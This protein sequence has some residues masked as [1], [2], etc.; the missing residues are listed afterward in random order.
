MCLILELCHFIFLA[1]FLCM[2]LDVSAQGFTY[3]AEENVQGMELPFVPLWK[4]SEGKRDDQWKIAVYASISDASI[5]ASTNVPLRLL[6]AVA[7][8]P[9]PTT[10][11][12]HLH[13]PPGSPS[14]I[15]SALRCLCHLHPHFSLCILCH[16][17]IRF[18]QRHFF[19]LT[20][21]P[22]HPTPNF[23]SSRSSTHLHILLFSSSEYEKVS[24]PPL[25]THP[26]WPVKS[27]VGRVWA[28]CCIL[29]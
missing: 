22:Q 6:P 14:L 24:C 9:I 4:V 11:N 26:I 3:R 28:V 2:Y 16:A 19:F 17:V 18:H 5:D 27:P 10:G 20:C 7:L 1:L 13:P 25:P 15:L 8:S 23:P 29:T 12:E 21:V